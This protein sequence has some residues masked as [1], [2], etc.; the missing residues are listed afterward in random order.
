VNP[1][2]RYDRIELVPESTPAGGVDTVVVI[3][4]SRNVLTTNESPDV[5]FELSLNPYRGCEHGCAYC[6]ARTFHEHLG[7]SAGLDF[8]TRIAVKLD[9]PAVLRR[10]LA[11]PAYRP[12]TVSLSGVT[13]AYQPIERRLR[14]TRRIVEVFAETRHPMTV[15]TKNALVV[16]DADLLSRLAAHGAARVWLSVTSLDGNLIRRLEP[17]T[18]PPEARLE[19]VRRLTRA[20]VPCGVLAAPMIPG[21][22]D[23]ELPA[24]LAAA[25]AAGARWART[26]PVRLPGAVAEVFRDWL[27]REEPNRVNRVLGRIRSTHGGGLDDGAFDRRMRGRGAHAEQLARMFEVAAR[28]HGLET[29]PPP[30]RTDA[31]VPPGGAQGRLFADVAPRSSG[32]ISEPPRPRDDRKS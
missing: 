30:L 21:L 23:H 26:M 22:T 4:H 2:N 7:W 10:E 16:R 24:I 5:P 3:D 27:E 17:R 32:T 13:D 12:R 25:A 1:P 11:R 31:F 6:Y 14:L 8:E 20:G 9:A 19:A 29:D 28:R 15:V 18:S